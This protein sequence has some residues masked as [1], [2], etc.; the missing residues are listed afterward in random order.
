[1]MHP[2]TLTRPQPESPIKRGFWDNIPLALFIRYLCH[3]AMLLITILCERIPAPSLS[4]RILSIVPFVPLI[5][6]Y[7]YHLWVLAS[8]PLAFMLFKADRN[9]F[10]EFLYAGGV[11]SLLRGLTIFITTLGPVNG[12]DVNAGKSLSELFTAWVSLINPLSALFSD[13]TQLY[14]TK[15]LFFS[16]HTASTFLLLLY[17]W[18]YPRLKRW[19]IAAHV[20]VVASVFLSHL[21]YS[22]DVIGGW[23]VAFCV[24]VAVER[25]F[26]RYRKVA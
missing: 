11:M 16:G 20:V 6:A 10:V 21:H 9:R 13:T 2:E 19:A 25:F 3:A 18:P 24:F 5:A 14:L 4:D 22:I 8:L 15:D 1:M 26:R 23:A 12:V 17:C 7:N